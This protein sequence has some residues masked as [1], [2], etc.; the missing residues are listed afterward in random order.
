MLAT[1]NDKDR[2]AA[3]DALV[4]GDRE[5]FMR[6]VRAS[7]EKDKPGDAYERAKEVA[8][9]RKAARGGDRPME[10][11]IEAIERLLT[12][13][14]PIQRRG[15]DLRIYKVEMGCVVNIAKSGT[16]SQIENQIRGIESVTTVSHLIGLRRELGHALE[17]RV[18]EIKFE[19]DGQTGRDDY[20]DYKL[21][22]GITS[23]VKGVKVRDRGQV[24]SVERQLAEWGNFGA[25]YTNQDRAAPKM[26]TPAVGIQSVLE[27]WVEGGVQVYDAPMNTNQMQYHVMV[28]VNELWKLCSRYYRG[29]RTD[30]D[31]RYKYFIRDGAQI[32]VYVALGQ[33]GRVKITGGEDLVWFAR[34]A[35]VEE[36]PV[37]FSYQKQV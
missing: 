2:S 7:E 14:E 34:K 11:Q 6:I 30:F 3:M 8:R 12:E 36:L 32:P 1:L 37:F 9:A 5:E 23:D 22:P 13:Q 27:D 21:V 35:G 29:S 31:G 4:A 15:I 33:N 10:E 20:R 28:P 17:Y 24:S 16:D 26:I 25:V 18:Y 19:L